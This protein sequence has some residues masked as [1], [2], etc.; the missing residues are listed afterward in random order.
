MAQQNHFWSGSLCRASDNADRDAFPIGV[1]RV[2]DVIRLTSD[3]GNQIPNKSWMLSLFEFFIDKKRNVPLELDMI[4]QFDNQNYFEA[5]FGGHNQY[6]YTQILPVVGHSY[7]RE[8]LLQPNN[9]SITY[10]LTDLNTGQH[11]SFELV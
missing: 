3:L 8:I 5:I 2:S 4:C 9:L 7:K 11:E 10:N 1:I 6:R